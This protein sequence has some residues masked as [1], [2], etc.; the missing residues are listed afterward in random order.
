MAA[1][2]IWSLVSARRQRGQLPLVAA[3][4][5]MQSLWGDTHSRQA[6][7][8]VRIAVAEDAALQLCQLQLRRLE[9]G[10]LLLV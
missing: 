10:L 8:G 6:F 5:C 4:S 1:S 2:K 7:N 3:H 9:A